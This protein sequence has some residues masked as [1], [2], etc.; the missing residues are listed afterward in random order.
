M[1]S[2]LI[3]NTI[4]TETLIHILENFFLLPDIGIKNITDIHSKNFLLLNMYTMKSNELCLQVMHM[5]FKNI[6][7]QKYEILSFCLNRTKFSQCKSLSLPC[8]IHLPCSPH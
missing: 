1:T 8:L 5:E 4:I 2:T 6:T 7:S 3:C